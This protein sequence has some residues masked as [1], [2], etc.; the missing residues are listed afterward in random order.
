MKNTEEMKD[1]NIRRLVVYEALLAEKGVCTP[2]EKAGKSG[3][4]NPAKK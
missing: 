1:M 2:A 3:V 4:S